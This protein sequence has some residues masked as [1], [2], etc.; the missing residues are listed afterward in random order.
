[1]NEEDIKAYRFISKQLRN[2]VGT[3]ENKFK[4]GFMTPNEYYKALNDYDYF[5]DVIPTE[6]RFKALLRAKRNRYYKRY[7]ANKKIRP[8]IDLD[9]N[10]L[11][12]ITCTFSDSQLYKKNGQPKSEETRTK[13]VNQWIKSHC[14]YAI[15]NIDY[16]TKTEREHHHA[17][18]YLFK[19]EELELKEGKSKKGFKMYELKNKDYN[20]FLKT[21]LKETPSHEPTIELVELDTNDLKMRR[22]TDYLVKRLGDHTNK[23]STK[24]RRIRVL[25]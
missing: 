19:G 7:R 14:V 2:R 15:A 11:V 22:L 20:E 21:S 18:G 24:N 9:L 17:I 1:M 6:T 3:G 16:G 25:Y 5:K 23:Q 13:K 12:F 8:L 10:R 4:P